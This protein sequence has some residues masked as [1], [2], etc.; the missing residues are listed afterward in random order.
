MKAFVLTFRLFYRD[1]DGLSFREIGDLY[2]TLPVRQELK[3]E[4]SQIRSEVRRYLDG[5]TLLDVFGERISRRDL[6]DTWLF[7]EIAHLNR[8]KRERLR[9][10]SVDDDVRALFQHEFEGVLL[11]LLQAVSWVYAW[12]LAALDEM[13]SP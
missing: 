3:D 1:R 9:A 7:G 13:V 5:S 8:D 4:V 6:L 11:G 12:N 10:W 2:K